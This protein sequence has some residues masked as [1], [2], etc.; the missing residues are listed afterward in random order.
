L[1]LLNAR[2]RDS[3]SDH[4]RAKRREF[5][6]IARDEAF[7]REIKVFELIE[8]I[9]VRELLD[10]TRNV[11]A[12]IDK[13]NLGQETLNL[14]RKTRQEKMLH[15][16]I[17]KD[18]LSGSRS[19]LLLLLR[20]RIELSGGL[21]LLLLLRLEELLLLLLLLLLGKGRLSLEVS[22]S[23]VSVGVVVGGVVG[24]VIGVRSSRSSSSSSNVVVGK[25]IRESSLI[26][27][28]EVVSSGV[29]EV[30]SVHCGTKKINS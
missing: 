8:L 10:Q 13:V 4:I 23:G 24:G 29:V 18:V 22:I 17:K 3:S 9:F 1:D 19:L 12:A 5:G 21:L 15:I 27:A 11:D 30:N 16:N 20:S 7:L 28:Q 2:E 14:L 26:V 6:A 25:I